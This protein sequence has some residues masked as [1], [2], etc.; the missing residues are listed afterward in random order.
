MV[1]ILDEFGALHFRN[2]NPIKIK[3]QSLQSPLMFAGLCFLR[4]KFQNHIL[5]F[6]RPFDHE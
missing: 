6:E 5:H 4:M 3:T 2:G 1:N